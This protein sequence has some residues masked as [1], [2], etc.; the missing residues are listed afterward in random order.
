MFGNGSLVFDGH[1]NI[2]YDL[3]VYRQTFQYIYIYSADQ[4]EFDS[5]DET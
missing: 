1:R 4:K 2:F 5:L 3:T